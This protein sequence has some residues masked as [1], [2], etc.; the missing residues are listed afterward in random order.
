MRIYFPLQS[1]TMVTERSTF[2]RPS[3]P[4]DKAP[5]PVCPEAIL[6]PLSSP[7]SQIPPRLPARPALPPP[8]PGW[9]STSHVIPAAYPRRWRGTTGNL[10]RESHPFQSKPATGKE[11]KEDREARAIEETKVC[12]KQ[13]YAS[14]EESASSQENGEEPLLWMAAERWR[15]DPGHAQ[16][17]EGLTLVFKHANGFTKE[18]CHVPQ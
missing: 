8:P 7:P 18:V 11:S 3:K 10:N 14:A 15:R 17:G 6:I 16:A 12:L 5:T 4:Y 13:R 1:L 9:I 2:P